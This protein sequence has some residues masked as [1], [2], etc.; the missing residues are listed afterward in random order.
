MLL[1]ILG[2]A[3]GLV[4]ARWTLSAMTAMLPSDSG[5]SAQ[6]HLSRLAIV[7]TGAL[8]LATGL[9][10]GLAP[11]LN[12]TRPDLVTE[13][14][15]NSGRLSG[16]RA[17]A[18][19]R[20]TLVTAQIALSMT[21]LIAAGLFIKSLRNIARVDLGITIDNMATFGVSP[22]LSG[23]DT[24]RAKAL[25]ARIEQQL[26]AVPGVTGVTAS[27]LQLLAGNNWGNGVSVEGF[28]HDL[29][30]DTNR[31]STRWARTTSTCSACRCSQGATSR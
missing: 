29:D 7:F 1:G 18:K 5:V 27:M 10:F 28:K 31:G 11:A 24:T 9:L 3:S 12:S 6:F 15:N 22:E 8:S 20:T 21:L 17:A 14:R 16:G 13:L 23:Y 2:G 25:F 30:T 26:S 19:F 4:V